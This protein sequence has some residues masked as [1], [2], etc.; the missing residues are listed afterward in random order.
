MAGHSLGAGEAAFVAT[1][2]DV[3]RIVM[4]SGPVDSGASWTQQPRLHPEKYW[5]LGHACDHTTSEPFF[6]SEL[7]NWG[8]FTMSGPLTNIEAGQTVTVPA[9]GLTTCPAESA[10]QVAAPFGA[11]HELASVL[12]N[13]CAPG[14]GPNAPPNLKFHDQVA[15][16]CKTEPPALLAAWKYLIGVP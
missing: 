2:R 16:D 9:G 10:T 6:P 3:A 8:T 7:I 4:L 5:G 11:T 14:E 12:D 13:G 15:M 1:Q